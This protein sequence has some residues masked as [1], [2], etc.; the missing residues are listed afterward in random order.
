MRTQELLHRDVKISMIQKNKDKVLLLRTVLG[1]LDRIGKK[2]NDNEVDVV[3]RRMW[4]IASEVDNKMETEILEP[5]LLPRMTDEE[6]DISVR[7]I[8][9]MGM[10]NSPSDIGKVMKD[11]QDVNTTKPFDGG[12]VASTARKWLLK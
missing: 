12:V 3:I 1:E 10:Y 6:I 2:L 7:T 11:F 5:Y 8:V 9:T 4:T